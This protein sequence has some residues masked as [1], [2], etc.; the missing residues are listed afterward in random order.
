MAV[1]TYGALDPQALFAVTDT[2]AL[3][4][5]AVR[6]IARVELVPLHPVPITDHVYDVAPTTAAEVYI[7]VAPVHGAVGRVTVDGVAGT[8]V[9]GAAN[10]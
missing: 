7:A 2:D 3:P 5:P 1:N 6:V 8:A 9:I 4:V 10:T